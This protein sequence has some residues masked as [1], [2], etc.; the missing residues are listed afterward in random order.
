MKLPPEKEQQDLVD[1]IT[2]STKELNSFINS[3]L[4]L[5]KIESQNLT[6]NIESKDVN[7]TIESIVEKLSFEASAKKINLEAELSPLYPIAID[8]VLMNRVISNL[9]E[10]AIKYS[11]EG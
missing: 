3:I 1:N 2:E 5:T 8:V 4:D 11:G 9:I 7:K 10:N 6:L